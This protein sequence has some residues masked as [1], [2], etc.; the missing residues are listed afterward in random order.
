MIFFF[1]EIQRTLEQTKVYYNLYYSVWK[2]TSQKPSKVAT[3]KKSVYHWYKCVYHWYNLL[4]WMFFNPCYN[5]K[6]LFFI[7]ICY[8]EVWW[9]RRVLCSSKRVFWKKS[10]FYIHYLHNNIKMLLIPKVHNKC[11]LLKFVDSV[12]LLFL[13]V[14]VSHFPL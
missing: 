13:L 8:P 4:W 7:Q 10:V 3:A 14:N 11:L 12:F 9:N 2:E 1:L 6:T 5:W